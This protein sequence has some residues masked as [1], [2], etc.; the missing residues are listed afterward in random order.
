MA[1][2]VALGAPPVSKIFATM[3]EGPIPGESNPGEAWLESHGRSLGHFVAGTWLKPPG[4]TSLECREA[5]TGRT[6]AV[7]PEGDSSDLAVAV[8][9]AAAVAKAW[10][11]LGGPQRGQRLT[12]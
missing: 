1:A 11:G 2:L 3:E 5:A 8:A 7:V 6:V 9:A 10:A 12:Q 4:R